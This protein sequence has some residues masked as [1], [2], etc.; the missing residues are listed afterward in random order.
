M[1]SICYVI[2]SLGVGG[3]ERQLVELVRGLTLDFDVAV[4]CTRLEGA[5][6]G[7]VRR[8]GARLLVVP[9]RNGWDPRLRQRLREFFRKRR[10]DIVHSFLFGFDYFA[11]L[12]ARDA[13]VPVVVSSRRQ[14]ATWKKRRHVFIQRLANRR[15]DAIVANSRAVAE[16]AAKQETADPRMFRVIHNG[17]EAGNFTASPDLRTLRLRYKIPFHR[18]VIGM[19]ANFSPVKDHGLFV[20]AAY[21]LLRRRA[22]VHFLLIG[23][24]PLVRRVERLIRAGGAPECFTRVSTIVDLPDLY[25]L[26]DVSVLCSRVEGFPN[27]LLESMAVGKPVVA[28]GVGGICELVRDGVTGRLVFSRDPGDFAQAIDEA[29]E[30]PEQSDAMGARAAADV[31]ERFSVGRMLGAYRRLYAELLEGRRGDV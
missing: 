28:A 24:G 6:A 16:F 30:H 23:D 9:A 8:A 10:P 2:P 31:A 18:N 19:V 15:V 5:H 4:V 14:L 3:S 26:I 20:A 13:G 25:A 12:A 22:D 29:L 11:N 17:I 7:E 21:E 1:T 27:S